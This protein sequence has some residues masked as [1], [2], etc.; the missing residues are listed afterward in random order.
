MQALISALIFLSRPA[1]PRIGR[2]WPSW[3]PEP[4]AGTGPGASKAVGEIQS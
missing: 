1:P 4:R 3:R 2:D